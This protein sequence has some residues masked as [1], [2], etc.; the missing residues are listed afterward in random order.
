M[1][2]SLGDLK[3]T[4]KLSMHPYSWR[5]GTRWAN[6]QFPGSNTLIDSVDIKFPGL[7]DKPWRSAFLDLA[8][9]TEVHL[10]GK[11]HN[12]HLILKGGNDGG[13]Y[14]A[15]IWIKNGKVVARRVVLDT[16][17]DESHERTDYT[18]L[19]IGDGH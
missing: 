13:P 12:A 8:D 7:L 17:P 11:P 15:R 6:E 16:F 3:V 14:T 18:S 2:R 4:I 10:T 19:P 5:N 9:I 1:E